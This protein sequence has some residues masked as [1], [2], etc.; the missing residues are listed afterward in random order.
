[1]TRMG[2]CGLLAAMAVAVA[3][4]GCGDD[5]STGNENNNNVVPGCGNGIVET[6]IGE[7]CDDGSENSDTEADACRTSCQLAG[8]GDGV[9]DNG[10]DCDGDDVAGTICADLPPLNHGDLTCNL[11]CSF[12]ADECYQCGDG[13]IDPGEECDGAALGVVD[14]EP[15]NCGN[16]TGKPDGELACLTDCTYDLGDCALCGDGAIE[17]PEQCDDATDNSDQP[18]ATC[19]LNC[20][21]A[22]CGDGIQDDNAPRYEQCDCG[23][24][25]TALPAGC[26]TINIDNVPNTCKSDCTAPTCGDG[27][28]DNGAPWFEVCDEGTGNCD[29][30]GC[31][32]ATNCTLPGCGNG[33]TELGEACD[34]GTGTAV[35][36]C[37]H[38][39]TDLIP[40]ADCNEGC[41]VPG[42]GN[43]YIDGILGETCDDATAMN[44]DDGTCACASNCLLPGCGN[45]VTETYRGEECD[46]G[47]SGNCNAS[48]CTCNDQCLTVRC[49]NGVE[50]GDDE[51]DCGDDPSNQ[52]G[53]CT[54]NNCTGPGCQCAP[55][56]TVPGCGNGIVEA[57]LGESCDEGS[58]S[59]CDTAGCTCSDNCRLPWVIEQAEHS[60]PTLRALWVHGN[61]ALAVG[62]PATG[63]PYILH[64]DSAGTWTQ[65]I[66]TSSSGFPSLRAVC[67]FP[68]GTSFAVGN[69]NLRL[70]RSAAGVWIERAFS[71]PPAPVATITGVVCLETWP[72]SFYTTDDG[73]I[74]D[75]AGDTVFDNSST[76]PGN[77]I[78]YRGI[79]FFTL[80]LWV[81][82]IVGDSGDYVLYNQ[83][84]PTLKWTRNPFS[85]VSHNLM[86]VW[87]DQFNY[88]LI[89]GTGG[90]VQH[91][92]GSGWST[93]S[94]GTTEDLYGVGG[95][96]VNAWAV[97]T[98]GT[99][100]H[101]DGTNWAAETALTVTE[102]L[103]DT[104]ASATLVLAVG[105]T[106]VVIRRP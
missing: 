30:L 28:V 74:L 100:R 67:R 11:D 66:A 2:L 85:G 96:G 68:D 4:T 33:I 64:R 97:G 94:P 20:T 41:Q 31:T 24:D 106:G 5:A 18:N 76:T 71:S 79:N 89:V 50:D 43:G 62:D 59:N 87:G 3:G 38:P 81:G 70:E 34:C 60:G 32:C 45:E 36:G 35:E 17:G 14:T 25:A 104:E 63:S 84:N 101:F 44:C 39:N 69:N 48:G 93:S 91:Y 1:M 13:A 27:I 51:C 29:N 8:C 65:E 75:V 98:N 37:D 80:T 7:T 78:P 16:V 9:R 49:G 83:S 72:E 54:A 61:E 10:E 55:N 12:D 82:D 77:G 40:T 47:P 73:R 56:C 15:A 21:P 19:R 105:D 52:P 6:D 90:M 95:Y 88:R 102:T 86:G 42:C 26:N 92:D 23:M 57:H 103:R 58:A 22:G 99:I 53:T 46:E